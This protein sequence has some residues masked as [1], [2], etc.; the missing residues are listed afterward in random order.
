VNALRSRGETTL[1]DG[2]AVAAASLAGFGEGSILLLSDGGDTRSKTTRAGATQELKKRGIRAE[3]IGFKTEDSDNSVLR[4]F[5]AAGGGSVAATGDAT[6]VRRAFEAAAKVLDTQVAISFSPGA[7]VRSSQAVALSGVAGGKPFAT[8]TV[9]DFG[10]APLPVT[11]TVNET[12][13]LAPDDQKPSVASAP[14]GQSGLSPQLVFGLAAMGLGILGLGLALALPMFTSRRQQR[15]E[16]IEQYVSP[17]VMTSDDKSATATASSLSNSLVNLGDKVMEGRESTS[18]TMAL[19]ERADLPLR[20]GEWWLLRIVAVVVGI[21]VALLL[22][23]GGFATTMFALAAGSALGYVLP[24]VVLRTLAKRRC[25][26]FESQLPDVLTL[27]ASSLSTGFSLLQALD[28]VAKD[29]PEPAAKEFARA[30]A[31]TRIGADISDSLERMAERM[32]SSNM[33][34]TSMAIQI[35]RSVGGNLAETLR[36]TAATLRERESL[37]R[38]VRALSAEGRLSSYILIALP[39]GIFL[40]TFNSNREY[41]QLLW[42][43]PLGLAM[44]AAG[45]VSMGIGILWMRKVVDVEV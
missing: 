26:K 20:A 23:R 27:V 24:A 8:Q 28:A 6:A 3:I 32:D 22:F 34:W 1:Y 25:K 2:V 41:V 14:A 9:F 44:L 13:A 4:G 10:A 19:I 40:F 16:A 15:V 43:E 11:P 30:L 35:Q 7:S 45:L 31:E 29:A 33:R 21:A 12:A 37:K 17:V 38:H 5:A 39:I 36:K 18:K 42:T